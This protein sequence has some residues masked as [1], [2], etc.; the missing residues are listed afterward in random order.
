[1]EKALQILV[2][3]AQRIPV[4]SLPQSTLDTVAANAQK[5]KLFSSGLSEDAQSMI[6]AVLNGDWSEPRASL[7]APLVHICQAG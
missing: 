4:M 3:N 7:Q 2:R 6:L 5:L 1:M